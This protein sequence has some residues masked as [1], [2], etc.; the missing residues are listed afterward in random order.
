MR[1]E[2]GDESG[3]TLI[4]LLIYLF[5]AVT[6]LT[7]IAGILVNALRAENLVRDAAA[8]ADSAQLA[9]QSL[10]RGIHNASAIELSSPAPSVQL[11]R[12]RSIDSSAAGVWRCEAWV[13]IG[14]ELRTTTAS[15]AIA[16]PT[17]AADA[18]SWAL[19]ADGVRPL[20]ASPVF[21]LAADERSLAVAFAME[22]GRGLPV[23]LDTTIV[24]RQPIPATGKVSTPCF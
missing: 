17:S 24:S 9:A 19:L 20:G 7:I 13:I 16:A 22:N 14:D 1:R 15:A 6:V 23:L 12:T 10:N 2:S 11:V 5:L 4:E 8:A 21:S 3:F 18:A